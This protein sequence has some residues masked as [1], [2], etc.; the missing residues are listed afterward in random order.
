MAK[1]ICGVYKITNV[2]NGK[3][4]V[5]SSIDIHYRWSQHK[6]KLNHDTHGNSYLQRAWNK[7]GANNFKFE[8]IEECEPAVQFERE[9]FYL[10]TLNPF[11]NN[12]YNLV[13]R[14]SKEYMSDNYMV[15]KCELCGQEYHTFSHLAKYCDL[16]KQ[17]SVNDMYHNSWVPKSITD[18][19]VLSWG[20]DSWDDFWES[21]V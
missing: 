7:H 13:R 12:G 8:I 5:G 20:Y 11:D 10:D 17:M 4:Y 15:K 14:I 2:D 1:K 3:T 21:N 19:D 18:D 9:Q 16:C 6:T